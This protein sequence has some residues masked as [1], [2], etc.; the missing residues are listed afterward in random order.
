M[1]AANQRQLT[2]LLVVIAALL[3]AL[4]LLLLGG[5]GRGVR[6]DSPRPLAPLPPAASAADL[7]RPVPLQHFA[8]V[9]QKPLFSPDRKPVALSLIHI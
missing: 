3:G 9:W 2:P 8:L 5:L 1:N 6:W 7:P 4:L